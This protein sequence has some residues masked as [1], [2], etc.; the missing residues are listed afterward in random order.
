MIILLWNVE[1]RLIFNS[2]LALNIRFGQISW[3][4][5]VEQLRRIMTAV[6][7]FGTMP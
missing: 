5:G 4:G 3:N 2:L 1:N 7:S 6:F